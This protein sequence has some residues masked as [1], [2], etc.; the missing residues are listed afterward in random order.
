MKAKILVRQ[1]CPGAPNPGA[2]LTGRL[3]FTGFM[4]PNEFQCTEGKHMGEIF[5]SHEFEALKEEAPQG[6]NALEERNK[7]LE[8]ERIIHLN[9][10]KR[11]DEALE[12]AR[13]EAARFKESAE[14][15]A[16]EAQRWKSECRRLEG[17]V[18]AAREVKKVVLPREVA[19]ALDN[20]RHDGRD[21]DYIVEWLA[22]KFDQVEPT[23]RLATLKR[24]AKVYGGNLVQALV[25]GYTV[26]EP[27]DEESTIEDILKDRF[28]S[29]F[30]HYNV[31]AAISHEALTAVLIFDVREV[32]AGERPN[33]ETQ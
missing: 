13:G 20:F 5:Q 21:N 4:K 1:R 15:L 30:A 6:L 24:Y 2:I 9:K 33:Q 17:E 7:E 26:E 32:L 16:A 22:H 25:N 31:A 27:A 12:E 29:M 14:L 8:R 11:M 18:D 3:L 23:D 10:I 28:L 19:E